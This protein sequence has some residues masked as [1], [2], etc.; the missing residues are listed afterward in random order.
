MWNFIK[1][2][3]ILVIVVGIV[4]IFLI[5]RVFSGGDGE[6]EYEL[7]EASYA[8]I[9][10]E[11]SVTGTVEAD[12]KIN[13]KFQR[14]GK[15]SSIPVDVGDFVEE[16]QTLAI[17]DTTSLS[18]EV[19]AAEADLALARAN[20]NKEV[21][22]S[23]DE[24]IDAATAARDKAVA[25][26]EQAELSYDS[27]VALSEETVS[28]T[29]LDYQ[30]ALTN[31][32]NAVATYGEDVIH[33]YEDAHNALNDVWNE[34]E[35]SLRDVDGILGVDEESIN[36]SFEDTLR[37]DSLS[38]FNSAQNTYKEVRDTRNDLVGDYSDVTASDYAEIDSML[39]DAEDLLDLMSYLLDDT[40][41]LLVDAGGLDSTT[42]DA[43]RTIITAEIDDI[44][45]IASSFG[46]YY[47]AVESAY[48]S[49]DTS[50]QSAEDALAEAEQALSQAEIQAEADV[51]SAQV[52]VEVYEALLAQAEAT[53]AETEA[54]PR[55]VDLA[56]LN[57]SIA[58][59]EASY[60]LAQY[61]LSLAYLEAPV[62]GVIT[63]VNFDVGE[64][65]ATT[66]D[67]LVMVS[68]DY[69]VIAN[70]SETDITKVTVGDKV[71]MTL[72]AFSYD[73]EFEAEIIEIDPAETVVQGVI[74][75]QVTA[76]FTAEDTDVKPGMTANMDI[77]TAELEN[78][79]A[80]PVRAIKYD[81]SRTYVLQVD[82]LGE[83]YETDVE[84]GVRGD[85]WVEV[86]EGIEE[87]D[88]VVTYIR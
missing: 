5:S 78:V 60:N 81:G 57:A 4:V 76:V 82:M 20:Y 22:G 70:V 68:E 24:A 58:A 13:L 46:D 32:N 27:T 16:G 33:A 8:D 67:F 29:E 43:K 3:K 51:N 10:Q 6:A 61:N 15:A 75:Y 50:L 1:R 12:P 2:R 53:L 77:I 9:I 19:A 79:L 65:I 45:T 85:Q 66:D 52:S 72:D 17:L 84:I 42:K 11:V 44:N 64:N 30:T 40:D 34:V 35:D 56:S 38:E 47:Q 69:Q 14:A 74:Y 83:T 37:A 26:L 41:D 7:A 63:E 31:Y 59:A 86:F 28:A 55:D 25:D 23:T 80:I 39:S 73:K 48:T 71:M 62:A 36:D 87:G 54:G 49:E 88:Q 21:A 18:I